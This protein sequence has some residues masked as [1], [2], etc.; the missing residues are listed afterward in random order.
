M[1]KIKYLFAT[2]LAVAAF[3]SCVNDFD[4]VPEDLVI[5]PEG[6]PRAWKANMTIG[7]L[8]A[9]YDRIDNIYVFGNDDTLKF[10]QDAG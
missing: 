6:D 4:N 8:I 7:E 5:I 2:F 10:D 9:M 1:S 3:S